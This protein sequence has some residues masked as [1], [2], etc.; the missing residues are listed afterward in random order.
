MEK[1]IHVVQRGE[2]EREPARDSH[3][4]GTTTKVASENEMTYTHQAHSKF[5]PSRRT[6]CRLLYHESGYVGGVSGLVQKRE[7]RCTS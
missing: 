6:R 5:N 4:H 3:D 2:V 1:T 7:L